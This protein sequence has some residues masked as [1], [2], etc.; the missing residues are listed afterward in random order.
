MR[1]IRKHCDLRQGQFAFAAGDSLQYVPASE[2]GMIATCTSE[3]L[4]DCHR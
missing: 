4:E 3:K 2:L 1:P